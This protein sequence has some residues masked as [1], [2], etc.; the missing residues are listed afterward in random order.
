MGSSSSIMLSV[1]EEINESSAS[2]SQ[3]SSREPEP[4][5]LEKQ[6]NDDVEKMF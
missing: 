6:F 5:D 2:E 1:I 3:I 4:S